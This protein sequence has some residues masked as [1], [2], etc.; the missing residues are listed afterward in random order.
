M[1][2]GKG[3]VMKSIQSKGGLARARKLTAKQKS[4]IASGAA[5]IRWEEHSNLPRVDFP[6]TLKLS[7]VS[8]PCAV[9][10]DGTRVLS[11]NGIANALLGGRS[12]ASKRKKKAAGEAGAH[13]PLFVA[14]RQLEPFISKDLFE[15]PLQPIRYVDGHSVVIGY[16]ARILRAVCEI[17]LSARAAG[18]LQDQQLDKA[19]RAEELMRALADVGIVA[20]VDEAT[21]Y[22]QFRARDELQKILAAYIAPELLP[23]SQRFPQSFYSEL[24]RVRGW[25]YAPGSNKRNHY[26]GKLTNELIYKQ[27]PNGVLEE[28]R[29]KNPR[30]PENGRRRHTHHQFLTEDIGNPHL[31]KQIVAVTTLLGVSDDWSDFSRLFARSFLR[32]QAICLH[33]RPRKTTRML[34][35]CIVPRAHMVGASLPPRTLGLVTPAI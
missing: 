3:F 7:N 26:I 32:A 17:W 34:H 27:L 13:L 24:H 10:T 19:Q 2:A 28:L 21:G 12:G 20:L 9:L 16:D 5:R 31:E 8:I 15:G 11:E 18:A 25:K 30:D 33:F 4:A 23:W 35:P 29:T 22:Q 6:G 14:P 1:L